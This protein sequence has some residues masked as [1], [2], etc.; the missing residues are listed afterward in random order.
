VEDIARRRFEKRKHKKDSAAAK[1]NEDVPMER[2][3]VLATL[4]MLE[5]RLVDIKATERADG[6][7]LQELRKRVQDDITQAN[8]RL[9]DLD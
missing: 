5:K 3:E 6:L 7:D 9:R 2:A 4:A 8:M 1:F